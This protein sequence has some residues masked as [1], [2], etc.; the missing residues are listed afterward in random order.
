MYAVIKTGGKQYKVQ[1]GETLKVEKLDIE[2][3]K[4]VDLDVLMVADEEGKDVKVG[5]PTLEGAKVTAKVVEQ[6]R[7]KKVEVVKYKPKSRYTRTNGHRQPF[8][9]I[10]IS[11]ISA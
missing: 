3:G 4:T 6:G 10:E 5:T 1:E 9:T 8:T 2:P 11:K 7:A